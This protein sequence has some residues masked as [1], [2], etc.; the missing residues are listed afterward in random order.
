MKREQAAEPA[1][2][3]RSHDATADFYRRYGE[4]TRRH[5]TRQDVERLAVLAEVI[6]TSV[7]S[8]LDV[9]CG[10]GLVSDRLAD[11]FRVTGVDL[12]PS[13]LRGASGPRIC[14]RASRLPL[15][16]AAVD[17]VLCTQLIEH[18]GD[19]DLRATCA[20]MVRTSRR[21]VLVTTTFRENLAEASVRCP[22]CRVVFNAYGHLRTFDRES[23]TA[24]L[25]GC[26]VLELRTFA[27]RPIYPAA[28]VTLNQRLLG[29]W[30]Y[31]LATSCP[32]C[33]NRRFPPARSGLAHLTRFSNLAARALAFRER[34]TRILLLVERSGQ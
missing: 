4:T 12:A 17:L 8:I 6:P 25:P 5:I 19:D 23:V 26:R 21:Y 29:A 32:H 16:S 1:A 7:R 11:R 24:L 2:A 31:E 13:V 33:G 14:A 34:D 27:P 28:L 3:D 18:L 10:V 22:A 15:R 30:R 9:G 20:E